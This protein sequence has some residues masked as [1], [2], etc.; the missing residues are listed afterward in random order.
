MG[1]LEKEAF[2]RDYFLSRGFTK[3]SDTQSCVPKLIVN[4]FDLDVRNSYA[5]GT[6][7]SLDNA[8]D[9]AIVKYGEVAKVQSWQIVEIQQDTRFSLWRVL[10][11][12]KGYPF[13]CVRKEGK[14]MRTSAYRKAL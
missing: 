10:E 3:I 2:I 12:K 7:T 5:Q 13:E 4:I 14:V 9:F 1:F 8:P 11:N 6:K